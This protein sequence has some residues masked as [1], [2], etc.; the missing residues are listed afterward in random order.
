MLQIRWQIFVLA[1]IIQVDV[2]KL[3]TQLGLD[4]GPIDV[5]FV[6]HDVGLDNWLQTLYQVRTLRGLLLSKIHVNCDMRLVILEWKHGRRSANQEVHVLA[7]RIQ[8]RVRVLRQDLIY[9]RDPECFQHA[10]MDD[11]ALLLRIQLWIRQ[12][13]LQHCLTLRDALGR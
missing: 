3:R 13:Q 8:C 6:F 5:G 4:L 12:D 1:R 9:V 11:L 7:H 2:W 10:S